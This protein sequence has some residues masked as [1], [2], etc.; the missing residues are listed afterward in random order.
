[1]LFF[2]YSYSHLAYLDYGALFF[3]FLSAVP[4]RRSGSVAATSPIVWYV[5]VHDVRVLDLFDFQ[6]LYVIWNYTCPR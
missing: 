1:M 6:A 3:R 5:V 4:P 2:V